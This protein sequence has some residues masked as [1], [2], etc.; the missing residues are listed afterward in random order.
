MNKLEKTKDEILVLKQHY[1]NIFNNNFDYL[2]ELKAKYSE[3]LIDLGESSLA[4]PLH[5]TFTLK[6]IGENFR[7]TI[8]VYCNVP[9]S[10]LWLKITG[11]AQ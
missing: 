6:N 10:P 5:C 4:N 2:I 3:S 9:D 11:D 7:K 1:K 8:T